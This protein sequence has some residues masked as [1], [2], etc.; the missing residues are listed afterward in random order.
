M[1]LL[2]EA[3]ETMYSIFED[4]AEDLENCPLLVLSNK[5]DCPGAISAPDL[6]E[7]FDMRNRIFER[8]YYCQATS[9]ITGD[10][11]DDGLR[12]L[13]AVLKAMQ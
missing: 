7:K 3:S 1:L 11:C 5:Q 13:A 2:D 9:G 12:W 8:Q 4:G 10:G 6:A